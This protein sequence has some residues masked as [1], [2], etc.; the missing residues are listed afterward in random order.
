MKYLNDLIENL[1]Y[2]EILN[3]SN[4][5]IESISYDS[6]LCGEGSLFVALRGQNFDSHN[7]IDNVVQAGCKVVVC[8]E[9]PQEVQEGIFI[10]VAST[11]QALAELSHSW[12]DYPTKNIKVIGVTGTNGKT[13]VTFLLSQILEKAGFNTGIIGT[14]GIYFAGKKIDATHTTPESFEL[15]KIF[16]EMNNSKVEYVIM[17]VSSHSL[18]Q[19]RVFGISFDVAIFTNLTHD[20]L[21]YHKTMENYAL[22]KKALFNSLQSDGLAI[23]FGDDAYSDFMVKQIDAKNI[24]KIGRSK[25]NDFIIEDE[26]ISLTGLSYSIKSGEH[27]VDVVCNLI[28]KFNI[29]NSSLAYLT[30]LKLGISEQVILETFANISGAEG[31]MSYRRLSSGAIGVVDYSHTPD[32]LEKAIKTCREIIL[33]SE[34]KDA[35]LICVFGCGGDRDRSKR[36]I[37]GDI[38][39]RFSDFTIVTDDN[40][41]TEDADAIRKEIIAGIEPE[42]LE[43]VS[44]IGN[45]SEA[46]R[47]AVSISKA[48]DIVLIA[49]KGH[50]KYQIIGKEKHHFDDFEELIG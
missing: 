32:A 18:E 22:A 36:P 50:E 13:T 49:G 43:F 17:E 11:R 20:H 3:F 37:M 19:K 27:K 35:R 6:R 48:N 30:S 33:N 5:E 40:P 8:E 28:G 1:T 16:K 15:A 44:E 23:I 12:F 47:Y 21:D 14:T 31:R 26:I 25:D 9:Y 41:R 24:A 39:A 45:R 34:T 2:I 42:L 38:S 4:I 7:F 29:D 10:K 46:I